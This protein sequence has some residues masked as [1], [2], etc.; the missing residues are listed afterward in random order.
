MTAVTRHIEKARVKSQDTLA[1][2]L[3]RC[4]GQLNEQAK[5]EHDLDDEIKASFFLRLVFFWVLIT[6]SQKSRLPT[7]IQFLASPALP[8]GFLKHST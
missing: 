8:F 2:A 6:T 3:E 5:G 1:N 7:H 4:Y